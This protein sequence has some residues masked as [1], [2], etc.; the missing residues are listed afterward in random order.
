MFDAD[1]EDMVEDQGVEIQCNG[2]MLDSE[3]SYFKLLSLRQGKFRLILKLL[4]LIHLMYGWCSLHVH[5]FKRELPSIK[6]ACI[7]C[8]QLL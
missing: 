1:H 7:G 6:P 5:V 8:V 2:T 4:F 3:K